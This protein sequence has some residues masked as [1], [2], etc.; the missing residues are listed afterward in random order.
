[1]GSVELVVFN[2]ILGHPVYLLLSRNICVNLQ[3]L[4]PAAVRQR[5]VVSEDFDLFLHCIHR[6]IVKI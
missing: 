6:M 2:I 1:M 5:L 4:L 3:L